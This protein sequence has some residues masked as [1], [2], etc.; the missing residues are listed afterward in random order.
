V[1]L[2]PTEP[3]RS[4]G[5]YRRQAVLF[6]VLAVF[7]TLLDATHWVVGLRAL[8]GAVLAVA[9]AIQAALHWETAQRA[10]HHRDPWRVR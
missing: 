10:S 4:P 8:L 2:R 6:G 7:V 5:W 3:V 9:C 1:K